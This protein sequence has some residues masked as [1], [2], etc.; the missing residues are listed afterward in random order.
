MTQSQILPNSQSPKSEE[1]AL[2]TRPSGG[3][4]SLWYK[5]RNGSLIDVE[6]GWFE[7]NE[8]IS[9][10]KPKIHAIR[11]K[12]S[13]PEGVEIKA[14]AILHFEDIEEDVEGCMALTPV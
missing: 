9:A 10:A 13:W 12:A 5:G 3:V 11:I 6:N 14:C 8:E 1:I 4:A 7:I 2:P